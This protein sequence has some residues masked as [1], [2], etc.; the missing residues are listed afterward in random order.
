MS[1][2]LVNVKHTCL[3]FLFQH[4]KTYIADEDKCFLTVS[5]TMEIEAVFLFVHLVDY[6]IFD[7]A[8]I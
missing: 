4:R 6:L 3:P 5:K 7:A 1:D 8:C 2:K